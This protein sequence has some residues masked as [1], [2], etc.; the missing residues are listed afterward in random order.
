MKGREGEGV[1]MSEGMS[2]GASESTETFIVKL[3]ELVLKISPTLDCWRRFVMLWSKV[4]GGRE[5][6]MER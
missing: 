4:E 5:G 1:G 2:G 6:K 3:A